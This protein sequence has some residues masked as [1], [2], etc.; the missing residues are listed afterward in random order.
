M[1]VASNIIATDVKVKEKKYRYSE[2]FSSMQGEG[3]YTGVPTVWIRLWG[4]NLECNGFGQENP[5]DPSTWSLPYTDFDTDSISE[6]KELPVW[7]TGC[8]SSYS[9]AKKFRKLA[10]MD[11][12]SEIANKLTSLMSNKFNPYGSFKHATTGLETHL[13]FTGGEPMMNQKAICDILDSFYTQGNMPLHVTVETN[14]TQALKPSLIHAVERM[15]TPY[16]SNGYIEDKRGVPEWFW[17]ISPKLSTS[18]E[19]LKDTILPDVIKSYQNISNKGQLK[20]VVDGT[21]SCW[22]EVEWVVDEYRNNGIEF[23]VWIMPVGADDESQHKVAGDIAW[24]AIERGY[25][26]SARLHVYLWGNEIGV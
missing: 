21:D 12:S 23:P 26:V 14:G 8:D 2:I 15:V 11:T 25:N 4:C 10:H 13:A 24:Q 18:G 5:R 16:E 17:S 7:K 3:A 1:K 19:N 22:D 9:W 20:F 6:F